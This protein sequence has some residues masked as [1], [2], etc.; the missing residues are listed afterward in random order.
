MM[1]KMEQRVSIVTL[2]VSDLSR[3]R[4]FLR[5]AGLARGDSAGFAGLRF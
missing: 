3:S 4:A 5:G 2:G 1:K